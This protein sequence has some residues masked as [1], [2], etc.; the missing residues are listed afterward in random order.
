[1]SMFLSPKSQAAIQ[2]AA[3]EKKKAEAESAAEGEKQADEAPADSD[4][5]A[6]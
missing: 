4:P 5:K 3:K 1:M 6:E 2:K